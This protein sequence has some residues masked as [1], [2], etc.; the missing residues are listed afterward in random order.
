MILIQKKNC[1]LFYEALPN[2][3]LH[4]AHDQLLKSNKQLNAVKSICITS[5]FND[6]DP[7]TVLRE[8]KEETNACV[9]LHADIVRGKTNDLFPVV[10]RTMR[11]KLAQ[12]PMQN[13]KQMQELSPRIL[14][15]L[16]QKQDFWTDSESLQ[17]V[18]YNFLYQK[19]Q[20]TE[21]WK[22]S[23]D[24]MTEF[25]YSDDVVLTFGELQ[26]MVVQNKGDMHEIFE[27]SQHCSRVTQLLPYKVW[28][29]TIAKKGITEDLFLKVKVVPCSNLRASFVAC[30]MHM[31]GFTE[32]KMTGRFDKHCHFRLHPVHGLHPA[33]FVT[34]AVPHMRIHAQK[35]ANLHFKCVLANA[36]YLYGKDATE[37]SDQSLIQIDLQH[38][39]EISLQKKAAELYNKLNARQTALVASIWNHGVQSGD[40]KVKCVHGAERTFI[41]DDLHTDVMVHTHHEIKTLF[42]LGSMS[43]S[44]TT[45]LSISIFGT[46]F[47]YV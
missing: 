17:K 44:F 15:T 9:M 7:H 35:I 47:L 33:D 23:A 39:D 36:M 45:P 40:V 32:E 41:C 38:H 18:V 11:F 14:G 28:M 31:S 19:N 6:N 21:N 1:F 27:Q 4:C 12:E 43:A 30:S 46:C 2:D 20:S 37:W 24:K 3:R 29:L 8:L 22:Q 5:L 34:M 25:M 16:V 10:L 13:A 26:D 42:E